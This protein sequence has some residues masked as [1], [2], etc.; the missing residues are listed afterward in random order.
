ML[1]SPSQIGSLSL[2]NRLVRSA[3]AERM[4]TETG[5]PLPSLMDLYKELIR[6]EIGLLITG[7]MFI[8][9]SGKCHSEMTAIH[10]D[11]CLPALK[12]LTEV[13]HQENGKVVV[14]INH[15]GS[16]CSPEVV[17]QVMA[18]S[19]LDQES[20][21]RSAR[22]MSLDDIQNTIEH[23]ARAAQR[24]QRAGFDGVQ[25]HS[26]HG[27]LNSQFLSPLA[28]Q[29]QDEWGGS[30]ENRSRFLKNVCL[31]VREEVGPDFP[32][33]IK[34]GIADGIKGGLTLTDGLDLI[35]QFESW[36]LDGVEIS[37]GF[38]GDIFSSI[39]QDIDKP[40]DEG[41]FLEFARQARSTTT[42][43]ILAVGGFRSRQI[44]EKALQEGMA[45]FISLCRPLIREPKLPA[46]LR[47]GEVDASDCLSVNLC[48]AEKDGEGIS[49]K[50]YK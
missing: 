18:P 15:G 16:K 25:I 28:N 12:E 46:L 6:G 34:F 20:L 36:G 5:T 31:V 17:D 14:Q 24:A 30:L 3:T 43:P 44:M 33:L 50:C 29:R 7:H 47:T 37:S 13:V 8:H 45:D 32:V 21:T 40:E 23:F 41:Y 9:P 42:L 2:P 39:Q 11:E 10:Q 22:E 49:C 27:Y 1:F 19:A 48:W 26:A 35:R 4:A 38:S